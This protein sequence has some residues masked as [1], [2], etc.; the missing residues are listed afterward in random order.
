MAH[1]NVIQHFIF[2]LILI[3]LQCSGS[4]VSSVRAVI[5]PVLQEAKSRTMLVCKQADITPIDADSPMNSGDEISVCTC[6]LF[7]SGI[8]NHIDFQT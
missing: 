8:K 1:A 2:C 3:P 7:L 4:P 6:I 5:D